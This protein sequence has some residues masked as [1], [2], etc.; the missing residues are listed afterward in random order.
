MARSLDEVTRR[1]KAVIQGSTDGI[2][3]K[4][5]E[6]RYVLVNEGSAKL[7]GLAVDDV[8]GKNGVRAV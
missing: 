3:I 6:H 1:E 4:D 8:V 2:V 7:L 5:L